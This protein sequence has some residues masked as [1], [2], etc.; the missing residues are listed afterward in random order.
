MFLKYITVGLINSIISFS[1]IFI[2]M[3]MFNISAEMS[4]FIGYI[5]GIIF[6]FIA[7]KIY[8]FNNNNRYN[9]HECYKFLIGFVFSYI[10]SFSALYIFI[11]I[12]LINNILSQVISCFLY[13][14][15]FYFINKSFV[16]NKSHSN[17]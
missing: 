5:I 16:F 3:I 7:N 6:S 17:L 10:I 14:I 9:S 4:N 11:N 12:I 2:A 13:T 15:V 8:T 1:V